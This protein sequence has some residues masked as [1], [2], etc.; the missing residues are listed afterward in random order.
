MGIGTYERWPV[1]RLI[2]KENVRK[3]FS[4]E[5][6]RRHAESLKRDGQLRP[7]LALRDDTLVA[8]E[9]TLMAAKLAG[10]TH[11]DVK[12]LDGEFSRGAIKQ[13]QLVENLMREGLSDAEIYLACKELMALN[14]DWLKKEL[15]AELHFDASMVTRIFAVD[16]LI[17]EAKEAFLAGAFG[18]SKAYAIVKG[19]KEDQHRKLADIL[20]GAS[21]DE[22]E[23][24]GRRSRG[25]NPEVKLSRVKIEMPQASVVASGQQ[26]NMARL[27]ELLAETLKEARKAAEQYD[28]RT[29]VGMMRDRARKAA[30]LENERTECIDKIKTLAMQPQRRDRAMSGGP[31]FHEIL[32][33]EEIAQERRAERMQTL[34]KEKGM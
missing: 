7:L 32:N 24:K 22:V 5:S 21:R 2:V 8:G 18:F 33:R 10:L 17:P 11:V 31:T 16:E 12:V 6:L 9:R 1:E 26:L 27:I 25:K 13:L 28:V 14:P 19:P 29:F 3:H 34:I 30:E 4:E 23:R 20:A 15:A